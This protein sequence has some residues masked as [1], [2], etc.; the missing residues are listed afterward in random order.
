MDREFKNHKE[1]VFVG[2]TKEILS[3]MPEDVRRQVGHALHRAQAGEKHHN[4]KPLTGPKEFKGGKA[5]EIVAD[6]NTD[7]YRGIYTIE[8]PEGIY[9]VD[10][11]QKKSKR[12]IET[13]KEDIDRIVGRLKRLR[14][15]RITPAGQENIEALQRRWALRQAEVDRRKVKSHEPN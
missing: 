14:E 5:M 15:E 9:V 2:R 10:V 3:A 7:T 13:P 1:L 6:H 8:Y 11:F 12:G 4:A